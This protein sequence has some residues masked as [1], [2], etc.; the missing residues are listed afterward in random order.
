[1]K[2][3]IGNWKM[4]G[5]KELA[6]E[7]FDRMDMSLVGGNIVLCVSYTMLGI[8]L[9]GF[10]IGAQDVSAHEKGPYTGEVSAAMLKEAGITYCLVGHSERRRNFGETDELVREKALRCLEVGITPIVCVEYASQLVA[11]CPE[12]GEFLIAYEPPNAIS[13]REGAV[14]T[15]DDIEKAH[16]E[17]RALVP[18]KPVLYGGS[19]NPTNADWILNLPGVDGALV[20]GASLK[21]EQFMGVI[22]A[23]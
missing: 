7:F 9:P 1:M 16:N 3:I 12:S 22:D 21:A 6:R 19:V 17:L 10:V 2:Y 18:G 15:A 5:G 14:P 4:N 23:R 13:T 11:S 20:G 8:K